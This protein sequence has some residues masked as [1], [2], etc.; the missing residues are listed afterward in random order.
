MMQDLELFYCQDDELSLEEDEEGEAEV[1]RGVLHRANSGRGWQVAGIDLNGFLA[2]YLGHKVVI[3]VA[4]TDKARE[5][6]PN[7]VVCATCGFPLDDLG[8]CLRCR[9]YTVE[10]ARQQREELFQEIDRIVAQRWADPY[11]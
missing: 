6:E 4:S 8:E 7:R 3:V 9:L 11:G 2:R 10:R 1:L 5:V